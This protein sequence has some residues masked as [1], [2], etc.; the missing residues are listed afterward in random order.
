MQNRWNRRNV[1][2]SNAY[3]TYGKILFKIFCAAFKVLSA[4][5]YSI[6]SVR[7]SEWGEIFFEI[8][9]LFPTRRGWESSLYIISTYFEKRKCLFS[10][11]FRMLQNSGNHRR[12]HKYLW[13]PICA[14]DFFI[15]IKRTNE[16]PMERSVIFAH[17]Y[18]TRVFLM[19]I[20]FLPY[21]SA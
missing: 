17:K 12:I 3:K 16:M 8:W 13:L 19:H 14:N 11:D 21:L 20:F 7:Y 4:R 5:T 1:F 18:S 15:K 6:Y 9:R 2:E 10:F